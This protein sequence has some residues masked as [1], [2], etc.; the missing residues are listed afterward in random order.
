MSSAGLSSVVDLVALITNSW[1]KE[2]TDGKTPLI[3]DNLETPWEELAFGARDHVYVKYDVEDIKTGMYSLEHYHKI[4]A[5]IE[6]I[7]PKLGEKNGRPHFQKLIE[8]TTRIIKANPRR[9]GY[10][11]TLLRSTGQARFVK[12]RGIYLCPIEVDI[13][14]IY[15]GGQ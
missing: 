15:S 1:V 13:Q 9:V 2:N 3:L 4:A 14:K 5:S 7:S 6:V 12:D 10:V 8:E 11:A